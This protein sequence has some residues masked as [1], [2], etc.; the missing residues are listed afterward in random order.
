MRWLFAL[1]LRVRLLLLV[2][3]ALIPTRGLGVYTSWEMRQ[4]ARTEALQDAMRLARIAS[5]SGERLVEGA[6]QLL[7]TLA[8]LPEVR[9]QDAAACSRLLADLLQSYPHFSNL[10][11]AA[12]SGKIYCSAVPFEGVADIGDRSYYAVRKKGDTTINPDRTVRGRVRRG[13]AARPSR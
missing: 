9:R 4:V 6:Q 13:A 10:G 3:V 2:L 5:T 11:V 7:F 1:S 8:R 12:P